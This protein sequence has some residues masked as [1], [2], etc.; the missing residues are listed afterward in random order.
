MLALEHIW[1]VV[2][3]LVLGVAVLNLRDRQWRRAA[4]WTIVAAPFCVGEAILA[5]AKAGTHWPAQAM[6]GG[7]IALAVLATRERPRAADTDDT[8]AREASAVRLRNRLFLPA[9]V[10]PIATLA[11][12]LAS[13]YVPGAA[14][15]I[16][17][18][19]ATLIAFA[20]GC[21]LALGAALV[22]TRARPVHGVVEARRLIDTIGSA[23][24]LPMMLA[25]LGTVFAVT[26]VGDEIASVAGYVIPSASPLACVVA[27]GLGMVVFT[28]IMGNAFAAFPVMTAGIGLPLVVGRHGGD[29][30]AL[31]AIGMV[32]GYCGTL[33]TPMAANFNIVPALLLDLRSQYGVIRAQWPTAV[34]LMLVNLLILYLA[35]YR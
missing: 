18:A 31:G 1:L 4:F 17:P 20:V 11:I 16:E 33:L 6:G 13:K 32:T 14:H 9:L 30:A 26:G 28:A 21:V 7:V 29:P 34:T 2:G 10:I 19:Q 5:A 27:Y 25:T 24:V 22:V 12:V 8:A 15:V 3:A 35:V 23:A